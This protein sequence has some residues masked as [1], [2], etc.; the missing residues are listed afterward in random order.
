MIEKII[1]ESTNKELDLKLDFGVVLTVHGSI[2]LD[3]MN[4]HRLV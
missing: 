2:N 1:C 3:E 4:T